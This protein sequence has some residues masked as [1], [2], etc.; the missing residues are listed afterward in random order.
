[1]YQCFLILKHV[2]KME[3]IKIESSCL[4]KAILTCLHIYV[5]CC[6]IIE[7][8]QH[9]IKNVHMAQVSEAYTAFFFLKDH[10]SQIRI[11]QCSECGVK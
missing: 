4:E 5:Y 8:V 2:L 3:T 10:V 7:V 11:L 9:V 6:A 1:M